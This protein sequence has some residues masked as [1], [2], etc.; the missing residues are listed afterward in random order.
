MGLLS[1][2]ITDNVGFQRL[3]TKYPSLW[4]ECVVCAG[5]VNTLSDMLLNGTY[6]KYTTNNGVLGARWAYQG[7]QYVILANPESTSRACTFT[8][9]GGGT[10]QNVFSNRPAGLTL[11]G[12]TL[13]G[14]IAALGVHVYTTVSG[15]SYDLTASNLT[16]SPPNPVV[17]DLITFSLTVGNVGPDPTPAGIVHGVVFQ[18]D[19]TTVTWSNDWTTSIP[20]GGSR[21]QIANAGL[22]GAAWQATLGTHTFRAIIDDPNL[23]TAEANKTN[24][25]AS[26]QVDVLAAQP[27]PTPGPVC[28]FVEWNFVSFEDGLICMTN[29]AARNRAFH[30]LNSTFVRSWAPAPGTNGIVGTPHVVSAECRLSGSAAGRARVFIRGFNKLNGLAEEAS[31]TAIGVSGIGNWVP[32]SVTFTHIPHNNPK[33]PDPLTAQLVL[34]H[35]G[36][37]VCEWRNVTVEIPPV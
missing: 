1:Y 37:G 30:R 35:N 27:P 23:F 21:T 26:V 2:D 9:T 33:V 12:S 11:V 10:L 4:A 7:G 17:G 29:R 19:G 32:L 36:F 22:A 25:Q 18:V 14:T 34:D 24:N 5:E 3:D 31:Q 16:F 28:P 13:S 8:L 20:A 15:T 6:T